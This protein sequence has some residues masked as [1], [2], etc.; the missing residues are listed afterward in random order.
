MATFIRKPVIAVALLVGVAWIAPAYDDGVAFETTV[1][2]V[3]PEFEIRVRRANVYITGHAASAR[4][5]Q[6]LREIV[7]ETFPTLE[8]TFEFRPLGLVPDW[9]G[10]ATAELLPALG[11]MTSPSARLS[12]TALQINAIVNAGDD[13][14]TRLEALR[15]PES[16][17]METVFFAP[18]PAVSAQA[19]CER[20]FFDFETSRIQFEESGTILRQSAFPALDRV[21]AFA[22]ACRD[23][24][25]TIAGHTD[26][27]GNED[28]NRQ[29]SLERAEAVARYLE[30]RGID[31][32]RLVAEGLGSAVPVAD[33]ATRY[34]RSLN[35]RI[36]IA[37][38]APD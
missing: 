37:F 34:G 28:W 31:G 13:A 4:H 3:V 18:G 26:S 25:V 16:V 15:L 19:L 24:I 5:E 38:S 17:S 20:Q 1:A 14:A 22:D 21:A 11:G 12:E 33:N 27:S 6:R 36:E 35:R 30:Q 10:D 2:P 7:A 32:N 29:L 23:A 8:P 9:W